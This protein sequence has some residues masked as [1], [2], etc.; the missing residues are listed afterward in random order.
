MTKIEVNYTNP[1]KDTVYTVEETIMDDYCMRE[2]SITFD[3]ISL[4]N[5]KTYTVIIPFNHVLGIKICKEEE[6]HGK[7]KRTVKELLESTH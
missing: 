2:N 4:T 1:K 6:T 7:G 3:A 5:G